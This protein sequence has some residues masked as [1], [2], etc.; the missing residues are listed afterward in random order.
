[1]IERENSRSPHGAA[2]HD[3][4]AFSDRNPEP[5]QH[6]SNG[7][8][9]AGFRQLYTSVFGDNGHGLHDRNTA[10]AEGRADGRHRLGA[11]KTETQ[12]GA[13]L[14]RGNDLPKDPGHDQRGQRSGIPMVRL[15]HP[16]V[17]GTVA[18]QG[19]AAHQNDHVLDSG[20]LLQYPDPAL[21]IAQPSSQHI[22]TGDDEKILIDAGNHEGLDRVLRVG[23]A[24]KIRLPGN[25]RKECVGHIQGRRAAGRIEFAVENV[26]RVRGN[27]NCRLAPSV[28]AG[29]GGQGGNLTGDR[30]GHIIGGAVKRNFLAGL[31]RITEFQHRNGPV[32]GWAAMQQGHRRRH[33]NRL[34]PLQP[35]RERRVL[36]MRTAEAP[37]RFFGRHCCSVPSPALAHCIT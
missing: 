10:G 31:N 32:L 17:D 24:S 35:G 28:T 22:L 27:R 4:V 21:D 37:E 18:L 9:D 30:G 33:W 20:Q 11:Q 2:H 3:A 6:V 1:V 25:G 23:Q 36:Q 34:R 8:A 15:N 12:V 19:F 7:C 26:L 29:G 14:S 16:A 5:L 13:G